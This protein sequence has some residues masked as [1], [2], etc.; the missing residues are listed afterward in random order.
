MAQKVYPAQ[1]KYR[2]NNPTVTLRLRK[3]EK[4]R[5][6]KMAKEQGVSISYL[7][8]HIVRGALSGKDPRAQIE[9]LIKENEELRTQKEQIEKEFAEYRAGEKERLNQ[10]YN[11]IREKLLKEF[12]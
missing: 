7:V 12:E 10:E 1:I 8:A 3:E 11:R 2:T 4:E 6:E 9:E 5:L